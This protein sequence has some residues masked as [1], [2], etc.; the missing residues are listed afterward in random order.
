LVKQYHSIINRKSKRKH[1]KVDAPKHVS[2]KSVERNIKKSNAKK[3]KPKPLQEK[4]LEH[5]K[6]PLEKIGFRGS[7]FQPEI[8]EKEE[9][10]KDSEPIKLDSAQV[11]KSL[12]YLK[13][14]LKHIGFGETKEFHEELEKGLLSGKEKFE[15]KTTSDRVQKGNSI[16][17]ILNFS[18]SDKSNRVF[19]NS[20]KGILSTNN[21]EKREHNFKV[22]KDLTLTAKQAINLLEGRAVKT[23]FENPK[24]KEVDQSTGEEKSAVEPLYIKLKLDEKKNQYG[25]YN[26]EC[27]YKNYGIDAE[28][29]LDKS[30]IIVQDADE[31]AMLIKSLERG[32]IVGVKAKI[33]GKEVDAYAVLNIQWK[34][35]SLYNENMERINTNKIPKREETEKNNRINVVVDKEESRKGFSRR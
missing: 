3:S 19:L 2:E 34:S 4:T 35:I 27:Y 33:N 16:E 20:Y 7:E 29:I 11:A 12:E 22:Y 31:K 17:F 5:L 21:D 14:Q 15:I 18:K 23:A 25:N 8:G 13:L 1:K 10:K 6:K 32:D 30:D 28:K 9:I 26:L 24:V